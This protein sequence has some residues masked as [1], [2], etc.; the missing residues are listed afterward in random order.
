MLIKRDGK[1]WK[2][3]FSSLWYEGLKRTEVQAQAGDIVC[4]AGIDN[5][6]IGEHLLI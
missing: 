6:D 5:I 1:W 3:N 2:E 4:I